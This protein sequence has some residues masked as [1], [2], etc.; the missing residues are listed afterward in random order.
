MQPLSRCNLIMIIFNTLNRAKKKEEKS[1]I[2]EH[3]YLTNGL[4]EQRMMLYKKDQRIKRS[5]HSEKNMLVYHIKHNP[6]SR[7]QQNPPLTTNMNLLVT[8]KQ[9]IQS[10]RLSAPIRKILEFIYLLAFIASKRERI[11]T[12]DQVIFLLT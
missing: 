10:L 7:C 4:F 1:G 9:N 5:M 2:D 8:L 3:N 6:V 12:D 11:K